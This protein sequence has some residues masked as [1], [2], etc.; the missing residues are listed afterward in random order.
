MIYTYIPFAPKEKK[1]NLGWAYNNFMSKLADDDWALFLDHD[2]TFTVKQ[3]YPQMEEIIERN[4]EFGAFTSLMNRVGNQFHVPQGVDKNNHDILYH[5]NI[6]KQLYEQNMY[7]VIDMPHNNFTTLLSGV[8]ILVSKKTWEKI[9]GFE[10]GFLGVDNCFHLDCLYNDIR[11]GLMTGV[12]LYHFYRADGVPP[13]SP[14]GI[15]NPWF[16][17]EN[18]NK[19]KYLQNR[20]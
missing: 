2:A 8:L 13:P 3:W 4:P 11:V 6:G 16:S 20:K 14:T 15:D 10:E 19:I 7:N 12:Y 1:A 9:G 5:R 17:K 18:R